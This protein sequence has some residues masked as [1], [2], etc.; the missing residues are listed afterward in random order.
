[1]IKP[2]G[3]EKIFMYIYDHDDDVVKKTEKTEQQK[4]VEKRYEELRARKK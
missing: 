3:E 1:M 4:R 2:K